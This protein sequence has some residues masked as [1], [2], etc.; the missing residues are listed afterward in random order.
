VVTSTKDAT[1]G[2]V[3]KTVELF[4]AEA[5]NRKPS[6]LIVETTEFHH[7]RATG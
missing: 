6:S 1:E 4:S 3:R 7:R 5:E 2:D